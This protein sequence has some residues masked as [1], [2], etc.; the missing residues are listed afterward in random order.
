VKKAI[1]V[2]AVAVLG[3]VGVCAYLMMAGPRMYDQTHIRA[4]QA[5]LPPMPEGVV[6]MTDPSFH[7]PTSAEAAAMKNPFPDTPDNRE[8]GKVYYGYYC[9]FC[10]GDKG[11]GNGPVGESYVPVPAD[12]RT[13]RVRAMADGE[14]LRASLVGT[15]HEPV[16]GRVV[17]PDHR[18]YL[19]LYVR[20]LAH[21]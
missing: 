17:H 16:L 9:A 14:L 21:P 8:R 7:A 3:Y 1:I 6:P 5:T 20:S 12:L 10:H 19:M 11:D 2:I 13:A 18:W 4:F 15:G